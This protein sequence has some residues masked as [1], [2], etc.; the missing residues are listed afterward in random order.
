MLAGSVVK[1]ARRHNDLD[2][3]LSIEWLGD[4]VG[5]RQRADF[6]SNLE[7]GIELGNDRHLTE[8]WCGRLSIAT[9]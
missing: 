2:E 7:I 8:S 3:V 6:G 4:P 1:I 9:Y 5:K